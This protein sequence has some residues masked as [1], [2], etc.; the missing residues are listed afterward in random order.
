VLTPLGP[1]D[2]QIIDEIYQAAA[3]ER[4]EWSAVKHGRRKQSPLFAFC[5]ELRRR[6]DFD[7]LNAKA[8]LA[9]VRAALQQS[10]TTL[11][12]LFAD[13]EQVP[14][15]M[16]RA[17]KMVKTCGI[18]KLDAAFRKADA[19]PQPKAH[20]VSP[21]YTRFVGACR[22]LQKLSGASP[23]ILSIEIFAQKLGVSNRTV[24]NYK[25]QAAEDGLL[26]LVSEGSFKDHHAARYR[27]IGLQTRF[28]NETD[29]PSK[30][31]F[32]GAGSTF[33]PRVQ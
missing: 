6:S 21:E 24:T 5:R 19:E 27:Y 4:K 29:K 30:P 28:D 32:P 1:P 18:G 12:K 9:K 15:L 31:Q 3:I 17:W 25:R 16:L 22:H 20:E 14:M 26:L 33:S 10:T 2:Q 13:H 23:F 8:A 11:D 7:G